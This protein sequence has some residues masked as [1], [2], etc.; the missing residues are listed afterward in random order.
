MVTVP[1][2]CKDCLPDASGD[3]SIERQVAAI[4]LE[5]DHN[6]NSNTSKEGGHNLVVIL[7]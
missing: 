4:C 1:K 3:L 5:R 6:T 7:R 2:L